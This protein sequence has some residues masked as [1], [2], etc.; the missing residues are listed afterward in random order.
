[1][2]APVFQLQILQLFGTEGSTFTESI[3]E[4][5]SFT[6]SVFLLQTGS[7]AFSFTDTLVGGL[8]YQEILFE[9]F[10][11]VVAES[12][13][14]NFVLQ[15]SLVENVIPGNIVR[16]PEP[17]PPP[18]VIQDTVWTSVPSTITTNWSTIK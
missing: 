3:S 4:T 12:L 10:E 2:S 5:F 17:P 15:D 7:E 1:M 14:N 6:D 18:P 11:L 16:P 8:V 13:N 9:S